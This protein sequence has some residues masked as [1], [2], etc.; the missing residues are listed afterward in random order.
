MPDPNPN[1]ALEV[2][3]LPSGYWH[4]RGQGVVNY[5]QPPSWPCSEEMLR[6]SAHPEASETF[7][8]AA[9]AAANAMEGD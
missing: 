1:P 9:V 6:A 2:R 7:I 8:A 3:Q 5:A 4:V